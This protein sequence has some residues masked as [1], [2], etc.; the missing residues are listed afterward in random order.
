MNT[1]Q[2]S[3][4]LVIGYDNKPPVLFKV[5]YELWVNQFKLFIMRKDN[6]HLIWKP[7]KEGPTLVPTVTINGKLVKSLLLDLLMKRDVSILQTL[8]PNTA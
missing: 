5:K 4:A 2:V 8:K 6:G 7:I 1:S 3:D